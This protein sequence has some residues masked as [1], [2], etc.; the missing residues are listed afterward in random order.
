[1]ETFQQILAFPM[2]GATAWLVWVL[3]QQAGT[4]GLAV[5]LGGII[6]IGFAAWLHQKTQMSRQLWRRVGLVGS[7]VAITLAL[8]LTGLVQNASPLAERLGTISASQVW[9][10]YNVEQLQSLRSSRQ[11]VF[12]NFT[13]AWCITC[14]V[15]ERVALSQ[16]EVIAAF[17][18]KGV[19]LIKAD[20]TNRNPD[21]TEALSK[22]GRSGVPLYVFYPAGLERDQPLILPQVLTPAIVQGVLEKVSTAQSNQ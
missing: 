14:L 10:P 12:I 19:T 7:M 4:D 13:A 18:D 5:A 15:N 16:S 21:I 20:W 6:L 3:T 11:P 22:F 17:Q 9:K 1:M 8:T 2:Y